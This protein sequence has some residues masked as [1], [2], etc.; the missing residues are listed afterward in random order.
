MTQ[1]A[2]HTIVHR[3]VQ[4]LSTAAK[5][6]LPAKPDDSHTN[7]AWDA[8]SK[9]F[10]TQKLNE[11]GVK[12]QLQLP[13]FRLQWTMG[14][15]VLEDLDLHACTH[16]QVVS[17][18]DSSAA[19]MQLVGGYTYQLH[20]QI[21]YPLAEDYV[22]EKP[23]QQ[24]LD[25]LAE[26]RT[27]GSTVLMAAC[28]AL[29]LNLEPRVWPHH[30]DTGYL[31]ELDE[32]RAIGVGMAIPDKLI[33]DFYFYVSGYQGHAY[34][35]NRKLPAPWIGNKYEDWWKGYAIPASDLNLEEAKTF[36]IT[37]IENY[38]KQ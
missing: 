28:E 30:F 3:A 38:Q 17:W 1:S 24:A 26:I 14:D 7:M 19:S 18:M 22:F 5:S 6:F 10:V 16:R 25:R 11:K 32:G 33:D 31:I 27:K 35:D 9:S 29:R 37:S 8:V 15:T 34:I 21:P 36:L 4:Y 23:Q 12:L 2:A 13:A 20:Y